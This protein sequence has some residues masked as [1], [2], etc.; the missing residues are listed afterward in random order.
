MRSGIEH[1][2]V[3]CVLCRKEKPSPKTTYAGLNIFS[4]EQRRV[5]PDCVNLWELGGKADKASKADGKP[6]RVEVPS[7]V[8]VHPK[9]GDANGTTEINGLDIIAAMGGISIRGTE[10]GSRFASGEKLN[11]VEHQDSD[12]WVYIGGQ[13]LPVSVPQKRAVSM[14]KIVSAF[15]N[16][17]AKARVDGFNEGRNLLSGLAKGEISLEDYSEQADNA[18]AGRKPRKRWGD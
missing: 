12:D 6:A 13:S 17:I 5:C 9:L 3:E 16:A 14:K 18:R 1:V 10:A 8:P 15:L 2:K 11:I 4:W 7:L